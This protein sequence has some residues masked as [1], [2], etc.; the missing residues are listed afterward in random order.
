MKIKTT[1]T[2]T[3][4]LNKEAQKQQTDMWFD[5]ITLSS[6]DYSK[7]VSYRFEDMERDYD[8]RTGKCKAIKVIYPGEYYAMPNYIT[9]NDLLKIAGKIAGTVYDPLTVENFAKH[10]FEEYEI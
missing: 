10:V 4:A 1:K 5:C 6:Y 9:T 7:I 8:M 3:A 2:L